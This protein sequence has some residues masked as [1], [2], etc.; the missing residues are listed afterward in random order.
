MTAKGLKAFEQRSDA[1]SK[2]YAYEKDPLTLDSKYEKIFRKNKKAWDFFS[3]QA[4]SYQK[5][6][7]HWIMNAKQETTRMSRLEKTI[8]HSESQ[9]RV[10]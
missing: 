10:Q 6:M 2:I 7:T 5:V 3:R 4:P 1:R 9:K 8:A